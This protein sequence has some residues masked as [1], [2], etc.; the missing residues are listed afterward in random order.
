MADQAQQ[1]KSLKTWSYFEKKGQRRK[2]SE[3]EVV[4]VNL[5]YRTDNPDAPF[6]LD[7]D[8]PMNRWYKK[9]CNESPLKHED[10]DD[11]RDPDELIY[12]TYNKMQD[13]QE[14]YVD[15]LLNEHDE[16]EHD[17]GLSERWVD[18]LA[19][20]YAPGRYLMHTVQM[21]SAYIVHMAPASTITN[22][23]MFQDGDSLRWVQRIAY[24]TRELA[25]SWPDKGFAEKER[26][27]WEED[28]A[29]QGFRELMERELVAYD[30]GEAFTALNLVCK[31]A[32]DEAFLRQFAQ[33]ARR[34]GDTLLAMLAD[35]Q[36]LD[37]E[38]HRR[39]STELVDFAL[40]NE[41]NRKVL[42]EWVAKWVPLADRA[43]D[44]FCA[45]LPDVPDAALEAKRRAKAFRA[46]LGF[47]I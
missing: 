7:P 23:A 17:K 37:S 4:S 33:A 35:A 27:Y 40:Q 30:W 3:Y 12:R 25:N 13:G 46:G 20:L 21:A 34:N 24:R 19:R 47:D 8:I 39:W 1:P 14:E 6:E 16:I 44:A 18:V 28:E 38:R 9:Y 32:I 41:G 42:D 11:F 10:W 2:P 29:W 31:I 5:H 43:I 22:C 15:G 26:H 36:M 45:A